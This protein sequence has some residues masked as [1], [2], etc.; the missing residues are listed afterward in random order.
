V[1]KKAKRYE[2]VAEALRS[3]E[4]SAARRRKAREKHAAEIAARVP[5]EGYEPCIV[6]FIDVLGFRNLLETRHAHDIRDVLLQL[7]EFTAPVEELP[8][9]RVKEARLLSR[10]FADSV[11]DAVV[12]VRVFDTQYNDGAFFHELLDLLHAQVECIGHGVVIRAGVAIGNAHVG[13]DGKGPVFGPAMV[14]AYEIETD[15]AVHPRIV[16]DEAAYQSFLDDARLRK[17]DHDLEEELRYVDR[18]LRVDAD[19]K[20]FI[21]YLGAS[22]SEFDDP[23]GYFVFLEKHAG[24]VRGK[25]ATTTGGVRRKFEWLAAYHNSVV[26]EIVV[27]FA[28]GRRSAETLMAEYDL[29]PLS[30]LHATVVSS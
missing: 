15:E 5:G 28:D 9:R 14:R 26:D 17:P 30:F 23:A 20:R 1:P 19:G 11:S 29:D 6:S 8:I 22:E 2:T 25:L 16:V 21:D 24:L 4:R 13:L 7:R 27:Q 3:V 18:L 12:R 10:A